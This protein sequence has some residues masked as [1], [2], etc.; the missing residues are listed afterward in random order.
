[1]RVAVEV[2]QVTP[3]MVELRVQR[4][5]KAA[6]DEADTDKAHQMEDSLYL[7]VLESIA[8]GVTR[9]PHLVAQAALKAKGVAYPRWTA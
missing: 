5:A 2:G 7:D 8:L 6:L 4:I 1:M 3:E 9:H